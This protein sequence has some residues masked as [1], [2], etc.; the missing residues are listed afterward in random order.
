[1]IVPEDEKKE[2]KDEEYTL[3]EN[4][5]FLSDGIVTNQKG[6]FIY[7]FYEPTFCFNKYYE[8]ITLVIKSGVGVYFEK[9]MKTGFNIGRVRVNGE[10]GLYFNVFLTTVLGEGEVVKF[11]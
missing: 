7:S 8:H 11:K 10:I 5:L 6:E 1:M 2:I 9:V 3:R 4:E